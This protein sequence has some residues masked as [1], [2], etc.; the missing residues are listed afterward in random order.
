MKEPALIK[1]R[2]HT[3]AGREE[4]KK[5]GC[6]KKTLA[7]PALLPHVSREIQLSDMKTRLEPFKGENYSSSLMKDLFLRSLSW[8]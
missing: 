3:G 4:P 2:D 8:P 6:C 1:Q 7:H 5:R